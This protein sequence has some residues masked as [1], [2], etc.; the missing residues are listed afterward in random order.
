MS[1]IDS[2]HVREQL[3]DLDAALAVLLELE[4]RAERRAGLR[5]VLQIATRQLSGRAYLV[6]ARLGIERIHVRRPAVH[7]QVDDALGLG[8]EMRRRGQQ[9]D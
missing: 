7:E 1:S 2:R 9:A 4:R 6:R 5:S 3:A 8:R